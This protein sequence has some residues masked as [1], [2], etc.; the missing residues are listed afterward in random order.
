[1]PLDWIEGKGFEKIH[2]REALE[3]SNLS[4]GLPLAHQT[5]SVVPETLPST[6]CHAQES[7]LA[8]PNQKRGHHCRVTTMV[9]EREGDIRLPKASK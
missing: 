3:L 1:M 4:G 6:G 5:R 8:D 7:G 9:V 2:S